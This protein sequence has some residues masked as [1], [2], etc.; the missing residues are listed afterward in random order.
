MSKSRSFFAQALVGNNPT[1]FSIDF[2]KPQITPDSTHPWHASLLHIE[3]ALSKKGGWG[4][5]L[6]STKLGFPQRKRI[7][8]S[9]FLL[10]GRGWYIF[11]RHHLIDAKGQKLD[12]LHMRFLEKTS[13]AV[14]GWWET[15]PPKKKN[16]A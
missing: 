1:I 6:L 5:G 4:A 14:L 9:N 8:N 13:R 10:K 3:E 15:A 16:E 7:F 11:R 2:T 12:L